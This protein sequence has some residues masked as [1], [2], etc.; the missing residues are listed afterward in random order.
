MKS[1]KFGVQATAI[2]AAILL[3]DEVHALKPPYQ[4]I[5]QTTTVV[6]VTGDV[7][8]FDSCEVGWTLSD[9]NCYRSYYG[10]FNEGLEYCAI[11]QSVPFVPTNSEEYL[12]MFNFVESADDGGVN[13]WLG[14]VGGDSWRLYD[15]STVPYFQWRD[16]TVPVATEGSCALSSAS[17]DVNTGWTAVSCTG[18]YSTL[19]VIRPESPDVSGVAQPPASVNGGG[20]GST[21]VPVGGELVLYQ[22][23]INP[24]TGVESGYQYPTLTFVETDEA[25]HRAGLVSFTNTSVPSHLPLSDHISRKLTLQSLCLYLLLLFP[26][27]SVLFHRRI[28]CLVCS[29]N[30]HSSRCCG[31]TQEPLWVCSC[32]KQEEEY[33]W[34]ILL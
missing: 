14:I 24:S 3:S 12:S 33:E 20:G 6:T 34:P 28:Q 2:T 27:Q 10:T 1:P 31:L 22:R 17:T 26:R 9:G 16:G 19:C 5:Y 30:P 32:L 21:A 8:L 18:S 7:P 29:T 25:I 23:Y 11:A 13:F 15:G 4:E